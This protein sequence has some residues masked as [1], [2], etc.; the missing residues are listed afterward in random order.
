MGCPI[1]RHESGEPTRRLWARWR[2][3]ESVDKSTNGGGAVA[4]FARETLFVWHNE[5]HSAAP[6]ARLH[7]LKAFPQRRRTAAHCST[8]HG[9]L[10]KTCARGLA[11]CGNA[12]AAGI[13]LHEGATYRL[14]IFLV[15]RGWYMLTCPVASMRF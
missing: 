11:D 8:L 7:W 3:V 15:A 2:R 12:R 9:C 10:A 6:L 5:K 14:D 1:A 4:G 13:V